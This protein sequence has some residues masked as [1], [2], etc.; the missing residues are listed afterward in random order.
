V[1]LN[2]AL[3]DKYNTEGKFP[4]TL[5]VDENG[6]ILKS[7]DGFPGVTPDEFVAQIKS[8]RLSQR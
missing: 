5:L 7:W 3:A 1:K 8:L 4:F 2:E 6:K